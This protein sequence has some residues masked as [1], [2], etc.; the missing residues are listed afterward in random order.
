MIKGKI[1]QEDM[2][3]LNLK[4]V[5]IESQNTPN[6][7]LYDIL[8]QLNIYGVFHLWTAQGFLFKYL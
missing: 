7:N 5:I 4:H 8:Y 3:I 1:H 2:I 6:K